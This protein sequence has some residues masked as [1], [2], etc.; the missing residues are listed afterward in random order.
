MKKTM[1][2]GGVSA[3]LLFVAIL[4]TFEDKFMEHFDLKL[5]AWIGGNEFIEF[6]RWFGETWVTMLIGSILVVIFAFKRDYL[7]ILFST[8]AISGGHFLNQLLKR[9]V[10]RERPDIPEQ[11]STFSFPSGHAMVGILYIFTIAYFI[12]SA[13]TTKVAKI[14]TWVLAVILTSLVGLSRV[15][16]ERHFATDVLAG[17][18]LGFACFAVLVLW[19][20]K[21]VQS[22]E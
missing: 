8:F 17:W 16:G 20:R 7:K 21:R 1:T 15:A 4:F 22:S 18:G 14:A 13:A 3:F 2:I 11:Y 5:T 12:S 10:R 19:Y 9:I 6:F